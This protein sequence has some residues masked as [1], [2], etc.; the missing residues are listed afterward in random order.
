[1][2]NF[3]IGDWCISLRLSEKWSLGIDLSAGGILRK[4]FYLPT[5]MVSRFLS[6]RFTVWTWLGFYVMRSTYGHK[7]SR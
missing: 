1:M 3:Y 2:K 7:I 5:K 4:D 6:G